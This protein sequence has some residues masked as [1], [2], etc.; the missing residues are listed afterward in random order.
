MPPFN[1]PPNSPLISSYSPVGIGSVW[2]PTPTVG[3][4]QPDPTP[5]PGELVIVMWEMSNIL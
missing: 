3:S 4:A 5:S 1:N 2:E